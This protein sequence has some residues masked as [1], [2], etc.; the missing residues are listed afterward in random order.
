MHC[1]QKQISERGK[2]TKS[3][4]T[5]GRLSFGMAVSLIF[6]VNSFGQSSVPATSATAAERKV[7]QLDIS[8][9]SW[10]GDFDV[11]L[12]RRVIRVMVPYSRSLYFNDRGR[13]SGIAADNIRDFER[14]LN[15]KYAK[16]LGKRLLTV[17]IFTTTRDK[18]LPEVIQ[19]HGEIAVG[20]LTV[21]AE[22]LKT[23][24]FASPAAQHGVKELVVT[25][26][27]SPFIA[28]PE[29]LSGKTVH[30]R[31]TSSYYESLVALNDHL[32]KAGRPAAKLV[33]VPDAL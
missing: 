16:Q 8:R 18:L 17:V 6:V 4:F 12:E 26:P 7:R 30:V 13:E 27:K 29:D 20:N 33:L 5:F 22:R 23:V 25:G 24:D 21:T 1:M 28:S 15:K 31:K 2:Y 19:G 11:M 14:W 9:K 32:T 10:T 3:M